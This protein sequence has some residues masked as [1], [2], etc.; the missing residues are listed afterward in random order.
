MHGE[1]QHGD[2]RHFNNASDVF[3]ACSEYLVEVNSIDFDQRILY[4]VFIV[5]T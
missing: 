4:F 2:R 5:E 3:A 1:N